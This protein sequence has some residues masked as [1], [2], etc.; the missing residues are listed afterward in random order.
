MPAK[1]QVKTQASLLRLRY[2]VRG[3][4]HEDNEVRGARPVYQRREIRETSQDIVRG[5]ERH[6][7]AFPLQVP[8]T[9]PER[10]H[11]FGAHLRH[12]A[13][14]IGP[15]AHMV[16]VANGSQD[17]GAF[18]EAGD[19]VKKGLRSL[20]ILPIVTAQE[21]QVGLKP[22]DKSDHLQRTL[23]AEVA[24]V[25]NVSCIG[26]AEARKRGRQVGGNI[27]RHLYLKL[28]GLV[29]WA[30]PLAVGRDVLE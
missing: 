22:G 27:G 2:Q 13:G 30:E 5:A 9:V 8:H 29:K 1:G 26:K 4:R 11:A 12:Q 10:C 19:K 23:L 24:A 15:R 3:V 17:R 28:G 6:C 20:G 7:T 21:N 18:R 25:V 14:D 16:M